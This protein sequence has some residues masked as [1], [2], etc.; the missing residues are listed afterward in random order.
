MEKIELHV[1]LHGP[2]ST[3]IMK[4][5][6]HIKTILGEIRMTD[7]EAK[8]LLTTIDTR[9]TEI[10]NNVTNIGSTAQVIKTEITD[11]L[12]KTPVGTA[13]SEENAATLTRLAQVAGGLADASKAQSDVLIAIAAQGSTN[14]PPSPV[15][16]PPPVPSV[17]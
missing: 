4:E 1:F 9:T 3:G 16:V 15:P 11:L 14:V 5:L 7:A 17:G 12:A 2:D 8:V 13:L 10:G 6:S